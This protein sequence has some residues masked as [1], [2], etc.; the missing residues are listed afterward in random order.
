MRT[1][2]FLYQRRKNLGLCKSIYETKSVRTWWIG[3]YGPINSS[4]DPIEILSILFEE[5]MNKEKKKKEWFN[6]IIIKLN[7][8]EDIPQNSKKSNLNQIKE[9]LYKKSLKNG[10]IKLF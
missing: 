1:S 6:K 7:N 4:S 2:F 8:E 9:V 3:L 5:N 10:Y